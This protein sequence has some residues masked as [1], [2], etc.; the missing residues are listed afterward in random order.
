ML[1]NKDIEKIIKALDDNFEKD[2]KKYEDTKQEVQKLCKHKFLV[3]IM[4]GKMCETCGAFIREER[5]LRKYVL[6]EKGESPS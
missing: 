2:K 3:S 5:E 1:E 4:A 6:K